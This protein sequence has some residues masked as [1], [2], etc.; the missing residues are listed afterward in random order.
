MFNFLTKRNSARKEPIN[1]PAVAAIAALLTVV[2]ATLPLVKGDTYKIY[3]NGDYAPFSVPA[4]F[5]QKLKNYVGSID[6]ERISDVLNAERSSPHM[7]LT[8]QSRRISKYLEGLIGEKDIAE[9]RGIR[10]IWTFSVSNKGAKEVTDLRLEL[11]FD[12][13]YALSRLGEE[14]R[15][16][17]FTR[18]IPIGSIRPSNDISVLVWSTY[19][20]S[21]TVQGLSKINHP[22]G[23]V[24]IEY[25][26]RVSGLIS[27][28]YRSMSLQVTL[29]LIIFLVIVYG[30]ASK[31][32]AT[33]SNRSARRD[34]S[35]GGETS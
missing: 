4:F 34:P 2:I 17:N 1:W 6:Y 23:V 15:F 28:F 22:N 21:P 32:R 3:A 9:L 19:E 7:D 5:D 20:P 18:V 35:V 12:G 25:P 26:T 14:P 13:Y 30:V 24:D 31:A 11:P 27:W 10:S 8:M 29:Y 16:S 33:M